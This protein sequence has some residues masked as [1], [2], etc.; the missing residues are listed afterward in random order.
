M[1]DDP[2]DLFNDKNQEVMPTPK[3]RGRSAAPK[4]KPPSEEEAS[5][6][7]KENMR[8]KRRIRKSL[9]QP[10]KRKVVAN[11]I[12]HQVPKRVLMMTPTI[13]MRRNPVLKV[14]KKQKKTM[15]SKLRLNQSIMSK[16]IRR[17]KLLIVK[18]KK[19]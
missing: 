7:E 3:R 11:L 1:K 2:P 15:M 9:H 8:M 17:R 4:P 13:L 19:L 18:R 12:K 10:L 6:D 16:I 14:L 5:E